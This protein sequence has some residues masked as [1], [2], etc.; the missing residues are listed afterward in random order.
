MKKNIGRVAVVELFTL[1]ELLVVI[2]IIAV[3]ASMLLPALNKARESAI[4][5]KCVSNLQQV[6][7]SFSFYTSDYDGWGPPL[8]V[9]QV[10]W[11]NALLNGKYSTNEQTLRC[12]TGLTV[13]DSTNGFYGM[14]RLGQG[15]YESVIR[16]TES[17]P[18]TP[19]KSN[20]TFAEWK[21]PSKLIYIG[22][23]VYT[24]N[25]V[26]SISAP[27]KQNYQLDDNNTSHLGRALPHLRHR[28]RC[29]ILYGDNHV[30]GI[31]GSDLE[32]C[33]RAKVDWTWVTQA[34][35]LQGRYP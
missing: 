21:S 34:G 3:L 17:K 15:S 9:G 13:L 28:H 33:M 11:A 4:T 19:T 31:A 20:G 25:A 1:I 10:R 5:I 30:Q 2:A 22:D 7:Y 18:R 24:L 27:F 12:P 32:D 29:N 35:V 16:I 6:G 26:G 23:S 14:R 8:L